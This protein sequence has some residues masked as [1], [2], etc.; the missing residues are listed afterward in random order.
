VVEDPGVIYMRDMARM[1]F[2]SLDM[3]DGKGWSHHYA[4]RISSEAGGSAAAKKRMKRVNRE[5]RA[6]KKNLPLNFG[7]SVFVRHD[8]AR[9]FVLKVMITGPDSTPYDSGCYLFDVYCPPEY[10]GGAPVCN[11]M[12][13]GKGSVRFNPN[14]YNCGKVCLSLLGTWHGGSTTEG[15]TDKSTLL[16][17]IISI[18][19]LI[20]VEIP[21]Y[22]EPGV[23]RQFGTPQG[24]KQERVSSNGG[25]E[26][27]RPSTIEWAMIDMIKNPPPGFEDVIRQHFLLKRHYIL[28]V[29]DA[30]IEDA[31]KKGLEHISGH[32]DRMTK[33]RT[34]LTEVLRGLGPSPTDPVAA[35]VP[36]VKARAPRRKAA[37]AAEKLTPELKTLREFC[38]EHPL[39][40]LKHALEVSKSPEE[41]VDWVFSEGDAYMKKNGMSMKKE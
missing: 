11:L 19:G 18:Q 38:P 4:S 12:T 5:L 8:P 30:W 41:A 34:Q 22:N 17:L 40:L 33:L 15:W 1:Q 25:L 29:V 23:E 28:G 7:S 36:V 37:A 26:Y 16:Q 14:L 24:K 32:K 31:G 3:S 2:R 6:M 9:P 20:L 13:T 35:V 27:L 39:A 10:P 21:Y